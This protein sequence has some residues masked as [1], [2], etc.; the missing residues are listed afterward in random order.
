MASDSLSFDDLPDVA[1]PAA[2]GLIFDDLPDKIGSLRAPAT[3]AVTGREAAVGPPP[4]SSDEQTFQSGIRAT[5]WFSEFVKEYGEEPDLDTKDYDY[6]KA[7]AAGVRPDYRDPT[8]GGRYHWPSTFKGEG[9]RNRFVDGVDTRAQPEFRGTRDLPPPLTAAPLAA[10]PPPAEQPPVT[11][12]FEGAPDRPAERGPPD[13]WERGRRGLQRSRIGLQESIVGMGAEQFGRVLQAIDAEEKNPAEALTYDLGPSNRDQGITNL[14]EQYR[15]LSPEDRQRMKETALTKVAENVKALIEFQGERELYPP[16]Q[17]LQRIAEIGEKRDWSLGTLGEMMRVLVSDPAGVIVDAVS[18]SAIP[19][20]VM[21]AGSIVGGVAGGRAAAMLGGGAGSFVIGYA[22]SL[23]ETLKD[24][25]VDITNPEAVSAA[26]QNPTLMRTVQ[27]HRLAQAIPQAIFDALAV[28][29]ATRYMGF[30]GMRGTV[31][32]EASNVAV[33]APVQGLLGAAGDAA[34]DLAVG[35]TPNPGSMILEFAAEMGMAAPDVVSARGAVNLNRMMLERAAEG[36]TENTKPLSTDE[37]GQLL[38]EVWV[39]TGGQKGNVQLTQLSPEMQ[40][41]AARAG[42]VNENGMIPVARLQ[43]LAQQSLERSRLGRGS[44]ETAID[45]GTPLGAEMPTATEGRRDAPTDQLDLA[46]ANVNTERTPGQNAAGNYQQGH[47][48]WNGLNITIQVQKGGTRTA[49]DGSWSQPDYPAHY[50]HVKGTAGADDENVDVYLGDNAAAQN[51]Y[52]IDQ[53]DPATGQFDEH[54]ALLNFNS[55]DEALATYYASFQNSSGPDRARAMTTMT[56]DQFKEWLSED[57]TTAVMPLPEPGVITAPP[58]GKVL[59]E[60]V[61]TSIP[62]SSQRIDLGQTEI[63]VDPARFQ[64]K[65]NTDEQGLSERLKGIKRWDPIKGNMTVLWEDADGKFWVADGHQRIGLASR[66]MAQGHAPIQLNAFVLRAVDGV[67]AEQ[68]RMLAAKKN[69]AEGTGS[70]VDAAKI[71][72]EV[73][74][75]AFNADASLPKTGAVVRQGLGLARLGDDA[76]AMVVNGVVPENYAAIVGEIVPP[77]AQQAAAL[78]VLGRAQPA[79]DVQARSIVEQVVQA[80]FS[81]QTTA[82]MF[83]ERAVATALYAERA[84]VLDS[85]LKLIKREKAVFRTLVERAG[86]IEAA[87]NV[88]ADDENRTRLSDDET[89]AVRVQKLANMKGEVSDALS[90]AARTVAAGESVGA[91]AGKFVQAL[92]RLAGSDQQGG[93]RPG[94]DQPG[95]AGDRR[96]A[97]AAAQAEPPA[98]PAEREGAEAGVRRDLA[99]DAQAEAERILGRP[100]GAPDPTVKPTPVPAPK[101][102]ITKR[103]TALTPAERSRQ[104]PGSLKS[105]ITDDWLR[106]DDDPEFTG[107]RQRI[108]NDVLVRW[109]MTASGRAALTLAQNEIDKLTAK[110]APG[111]RAIIATELIAEAQKVGGFY[112]DDW[113]VQGKGDG[114]WRRFSM[115]VAVVAIAGHGQTISHEIVHFLKRAGYI[116]PKEWDALAAQAD[117][118]RKQYGTDAFYEDLVAR[119]DIER[120][121]EEAVAQMF[122]EWLMGN[123][124]GGLAELFPVEEG[125]TAQQRTLA[126]RAFAKLKA[127]MQQVWEKLRGIDPELGP[128]AIFEA[129]AEGD[130][131]RRT[132]NRWDYSKIEGSN[133]EATKTVPIS[134]TLDGLG[135][136]LEDEAER[137]RGLTTDKERA[138][139]AMRG[140]ARAKR[141]QTSDAGPLFQGQDDLFADLPTTETPKPPTDDT[142]QGNLFSRMPREAK[143]ALAEAGIDEATAEAEL[144]AYSR[145]IGSIIKAAATSTKNAVTGKVDEDGVWVRGP[146]KDPRNLTGKELF[147]AWLL[148]PDRAFSGRPELSALI[149]KEVDASVLEHRMAQR[150]VRNWDQI[151]RGLPKENYAEMARLLWVGDALKEDFTRRKPGKNDPLVQIERGEFEYEDEHGITHKLPKM[152]IRSI[153][154]YREARKLLE[155]VATMIDRHNKAMRPD[156]VKERTRLLNQMAQMRIWSDPEFRKLYGRRTRLRRRMRANGVLPGVLD[157]EMARVELALDDLRR[158]NEN[159]KDLEQR[160]D[161]VSDRILAL[162]VKKNPGYVPHLFIGSWRVFQLVPDVDNGGLKQ[163][164]IPAS[165][166]GFFQ[167]LEDAVRGAKRYAELNGI[168]NDQFMVAPKEFQ[169][170]FQGNEAT[171]ISDRNYGRYARM[172]G[173]HLGISGQELRD[174]MNNPRIVQTRYRRRLASFMRE[175][176]GAEGFAENIDLVLRHHLNSAVRYMMRDRMK[177]AWINAQESNPEAFGGS[178]TET[179][180]S[181]LAAEV[182]ALLRDINGQK[183]PVEASID[184]HLTGRRPITMALW[185]VALAGFPLGVLTSAPIM[186]TAVGAWL[187]ST[188]YRG[189]NRGGDFPTRAITSQMLS[190]LSHLKLGMVFNAGSAVTNLYTIATN[191]YPLLGEKWTG[192]GLYRAGKAFLQ[193]VKV[194]KDEIIA[195]Q[196]GETYVY[197]SPGREYE[198][199]RRAGIFFDPRVAEQSPHLHEAP[200]N[201]GML[202]MLLFSSTETANRATTYLG[203]YSKA[204]AEGK[205]PAE[206]QRYADH[207]ITETQFR[208]SQG[209]KPRLLRG[210]IARVPLQ[211]K[212]FWIRQLLFA[213]DSLWPS[214]TKALGNPKRALRF[215]VAVTLF[216]GLFAM[217]FA[218]DLDDILRQLFKFSALDEARKLMARAQ[219]AG[220]PMASM[221]NVLFRGAPAMFGVNMSDRTGQARMVRTAKD[222]LGPAI[223]STVDQLQLAI[224]EATLGDHLRALSPGVGAPVK[225]LEAAAMGRDTRELFSLDP[226]RLAEQTTAFKED[227]L[228]PGFRYT[229]PR[230][231]GEIEWGITTAP[232][233]WQIG[234]SLMG[235]EPI[236]LTHLRDVTITAS[237]QVDAYR[238]R[239]APYDRKIVR[240]AIAHGLYGDADYGTL[241]GETAKI[242]QEALDAGAPYGK[243]SIGRLIDDANTERAERSVKQTPRVVRP[244]PREMLEGVRAKYG[245]AQLQDDD[246]LGSAL[247]EWLGRLNLLGADSN[248]QRE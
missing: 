7:W 218:A 203:A 157:A 90:Q 180:Q 123:V 45:R 146:G 139:A 238:R 101:V 206:A 216:S 63:G 168:P 124:H 68:A 82:D 128:A 172:L 199:L 20:A 181:P 43:A 134:A 37:A 34:S 136:R 51:V 229:N 126:Q 167:T 162:S 121:R 119:G 1:Q 13:L 183:Q 207:I 67:T 150:L 224:E 141:D 170:P 80:G 220:E 166:F 55:P 87:G 62:V 6:R 25:G 111:L 46:A 74:I 59:A 53:I 66:L 235:F 125:L 194:K 42:V 76:F 102:E 163:V 70:A 11:P 38:T 108:W 236:A 97:G 154:A 140:R 201:W 92:R 39:A 122:S 84:K 178:P 78:Q 96:D 85:A 148:P 227:L 153:R 190:D 187:G 27:N 198:L 149:R 79:N 169:W 89:L 231:K 213:F 221:A 18:E 243:G 217:P 94:G 22:Q 35:K 61:E 118:W 23:G 86:T 205:S 191:T 100:L 197:K 196:K 155:T 212:Y 106:G 225:M 202:S 145:S 204:T 132:P 135:N 113:K 4:Q 109:N 161:T 137:F 159:Y 105:R 72:R 104:K 103:P 3:V 56:I 69:L 210:T 246:T 99:A 54:K 5:P 16:G 64:F 151:T 52:V 215:L 175:R 48:D 240:L 248:D 131:G 2:G 9:H 143:D 160:L 116:T 117:R 171:T 75:D 107:V 152:S 233:D 33:Q 142:D 28:G 173:E 12:D 17:A 164:H 138:E 57:T 21:A 83:G 219:A 65:A 234:L 244:E 144:N 241:F 95:G 110:M 239:R 242:A 77:G 177:F 222:L 223:G 232:T 44:L 185:T 49:S 195:K 93:S 189:M 158:T 73:G 228:K 8:D 230:K 209:S 211:F 50:G 26:L 91:A 58:G 31:P 200:S 15:F 36:S 32:G 193:S 133:I 184:Q 245:I 47:H 129:I 71:I 127:W 237:H 81:E 130:I 29:A 188:V 60:E 247:A 165:E 10:I 24:L 40:D 41:L 114:K 98:A 156:L 214:K 186:S 115:H 14:R 112:N 19:S 208:Y 226:E 147:G 88:L 30:R 192:V 176:K 182:A 120:L 174:V 179:K